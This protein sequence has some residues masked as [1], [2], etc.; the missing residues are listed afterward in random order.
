MWITLN[1]TVNADEN[2]K[3]KV[4]VRT[5]KNNKQKLIDTDNSMVVT[6]KRGVGEVVKGK[7]GQM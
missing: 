3:E 7:G 6:E 4:I 5:N 1:E 2:A